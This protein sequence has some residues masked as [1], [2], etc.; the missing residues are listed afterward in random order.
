M[1]VLR[2]KK[3]YS[4]PLF[5]G[6]ACLLFV[7]AWLSAALSSN[8]LQDIAQKASQRLHDKA[9]TS[10]EGLRRLLSKDPAGNQQVLANF[11]TDESI[12]L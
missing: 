4:L 9:E 8:S 11:Y 2:M 6:L 5:L 7:L 3:K 12:G 10:K 1:S